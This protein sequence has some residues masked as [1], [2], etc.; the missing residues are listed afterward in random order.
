MEEMEEMEK[1]HAVL[2]EFRMKNCISLSEKKSKIMIMNHD[3][4]DRE[5][6]WT[7]GNTKLKPNR[8]SY[9]SWRNN[10]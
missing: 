4:T 1:M 2:E 7:V 10:Q 5:K 9:L 6:V 8:E 3:Q